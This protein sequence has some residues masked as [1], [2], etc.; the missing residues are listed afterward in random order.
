MT[1]NTYSLSYPGEIQVQLNTNGVQ[2]TVGSGNPVTYSDVSDIEETVT[3][4]QG[5]QYQLKG[6][7]LF[8]P[9]AGSDQPPLFPTTASCAANIPALPSGQGQ[10]TTLPLILLGLVFVV[11][12]AVLFLVFYRGQN[13]VLLRAKGWLKRSKSP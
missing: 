9:D 10:S 12:A 1:D 11:V 2:V 8:P 13:T 6:L 4:T 3:D 7:T 5:F